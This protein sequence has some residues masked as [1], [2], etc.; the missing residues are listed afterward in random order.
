MVLH[1]LTLTCTLCRYMLYC[2]LHPKY[3]SYLESGYQ[4]TSELA[5]SLQKIA[6][7]VC[8]TSG[9]Y[10][11]SFLHI[12]AIRCDTGKSITWKRLTA[13]CKCYC[14][15]WNAFTKTQQ[16]KKRWNAAESIPLDNNCA[17]ATNYLLQKMLHSLSINSPHSSFSCV[18]CWAISGSS[19]RNLCRSSK[20]RPALSRGSA[21]PSIADIPNVNKPKHPA[22]AARTF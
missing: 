17:A 7:A 20:W 12:N 2:Y 9:K 16:C 10:L 15:A 3:T 21:S 4:I 13:C 22:S 1:P 11:P 19:I 18:V 14:N 6:E 5:T 8:Q